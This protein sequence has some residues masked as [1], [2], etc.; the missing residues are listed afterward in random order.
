MEALLR[1][2]CSWRGLGTVIGPIRISIDARNW[3]L[4]RLLAEGITRSLT[5]PIA[6]TLR[7]EDR[8][9][10]EE[11]DACPQPHITSTE[12]PPRNKREATSCLRMAIVD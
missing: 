11:R 10:T 3:V 12:G 9:P 1:R 7:F 6:S 2:F 5:R 4:V 8:V